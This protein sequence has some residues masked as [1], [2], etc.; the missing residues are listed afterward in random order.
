MQALTDIP[1]PC[2]V[3]YQEEPPGTLQLT[4]AHKRGRQ[5]MLIRKYMGTNVAATD[6]YIPPVTDPARAGRYDRYFLVSF[7]AR[8]E[9]AIHRLTVRLRTQD[10]AW[11]GAYGDRNRSSKTVMVSQRTWEAHEALLGPFQADVACGVSLELEP[12]PK[13]APNSL[14]IS[15]LRIAEV[16]P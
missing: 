2:L 12:G 13:L 7:Q 6:R 1:D 4:R 10:N 8:V 9:A 14:F 5:L 11:F 16:E 15:K 3:R